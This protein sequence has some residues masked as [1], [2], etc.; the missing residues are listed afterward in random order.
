MAFLTNAVIIIGALVLSGI[1]IVYNLNL[2][3]DNTFLLLHF[4]PPMII[5]AGV[6]TLV[7]SRIIRNRMEILLDGIQEVADGN[8]DVQIESKRPNEYSVIYENFNRMVTEL[9]L[10]KEEMQQFT[11]EFSHEF[12]TPITSIHGFAEYLVKTGTEIETPER[13]QYLQVIADESMRLSELS[14][15][16][17]L[18]SKVEACQIITDKAEFDLSEQIK[19]CVILLL[20]QIE[21]KKIRMELELQ[22]IQYYGNAELL[23]QV[24]INLLNNAIKFTPE[25]GEITIEGKQDG[26]NIFIHV[27]DNGIGMDGETAS[28]IFEKYYQGAVGRSKGGNGVG[29]SIVQRIVTLCGG[30]VEVVSSPG[31]GSTFKVC[32]PDMAA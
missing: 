26:K 5:A 28:H 31:S 24:W 7:I 13:M 1:I 16:I 22:D 29:L 19:N 18:L 9:K 14:Q 23:E 15:N 21:K 12:K 4:F 17:L 25:N 10:T 8:L 30:W 6:S 20:P 11:N 32:L 3:Q 27:S 2:Q